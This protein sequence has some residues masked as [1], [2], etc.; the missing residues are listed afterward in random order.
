GTAKLEVVGAGLDA[1]VKLEYLST[2][3]AEA[4]RAD[5]L[6]LASG[7]RLADARAT[8][9]PGVPLTRAAVGAVGAGLTGLIEGVDTDADEPASIVHIPPGRLIASHLLSGSTIWLIVL[10]VAVVVGA[11]VG[12]PWVLFTIIP[13]LIGFGAYWF[14]SITRAL[15][16]S[17]APTSAGV[18]LTFG[19]FTTITEVLP[20]GRVHAIEIHQPVLWRRFGWWAIRVNRLSGRAATDTQSLQNSDVLPV[21][22]RDDVE[23]VLRLL[24]PGLS[25]P[26]W[27][28]VV[29]HGMQGPVKRDRG[30]DAAVS[31]GLA[32]DDPARSAVDPYTTTPRR[33]RWLR[34][35]SWRRNGFLLTVDALL[36]RRGAVRR[37]LIIL[38]LARLQSVRVSQGPVDR[39][40][41]V[42]GITGHTVIGVV[43]GTLGIVD[44]VA[45]YDLWQRTARGMVAAAAA[46]RSHRWS[47]E[48]IVSAATDTEVD[49]SDS[50]GASVPDTAS[51]ADVMPVAEAREPGAP[52]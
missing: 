49:A 24:I 21:G 41:A 25:A 35:L 17:I 16:Y 51:V 27:D 32:S 39:A 28:E 30:A 44:R 34:P 23:R 11:I 3:S 6:R 40:M 47:A 52:A 12:T 50:D 15:R 9:A 46:D 1:N 37:S 38:P 20:P 18:R 13:A 14:R 31:D 4:V 42:A 43:S 45:A 19:L 8:G 2:A 29:T 36:L 48:P 5:I 22:T 7:R 26:Q 33:A 10:L